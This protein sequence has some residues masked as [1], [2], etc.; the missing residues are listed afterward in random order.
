H[1]DFDGGFTQNPNGTGPYELVSHQVGGKSVLRK[2]KR[3]YWGENLD[4]KEHPY[5]GGPIYLDEIIY[6]D[7]GG[8]GSAQL[9]ALQSGQVDLIYEFDVS[10]LQMANNL[11]NINVLV[12]STAT[13]SCMRMDV[14][15]KP[16]DDKRVRQAMQICTDVEAYPRLMFGGKAEIGE[17]HHVAQIH[18]EYYELPKPKQDIARAKKL[19]AEAGYENGLSVTIDCGNTGGPY[20]Q[21]QCEIWKEQLAKAGVNLSLNVMP[22][23][24]YWEIWDKTP[25][26]I[27]E[28]VH[29]PLGTMVLSL[30]YRSGVPWN[31]TNY[32][33]PDFDRALS[34]AEAVLDVDERR[35]KMEK[36]ERILQ[37]DAVMSQPVWKPRYTA[38]STKVKGFEL[39]PTNYHQ[40]HRVW[41]EG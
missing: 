12:K 35:K 40:L 3:P 1:R 41:L 4:P 6:V 28:W 16:F 29:R 24:K 34:E 27:T 13:T 25:L 10:S 17:H 20:Q 36:V 38:A 23:S 21:Q 26:G 15:A 31:E 2:A 22:S 30:G 32:S 14:T 8:V 39:Q 9:A 19:L 7:H 5:I 37:E 11:P 33:N 18:P